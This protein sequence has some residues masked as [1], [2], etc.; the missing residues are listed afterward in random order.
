M[1]T[2]LTFVLFLCCSP[3][4]AARLPSS[5]AALEI[6]LFSRTALTEARVNGARI[7]APHT[8]VYQGQVTLEVKGAKPLILNSLNVTTRAGHLILIA[9]IPLEQYVASV[10]AGA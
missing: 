5:D 3:V 7:H 9:H 10:L 2:R 6:R 1:A 4:S 8:G